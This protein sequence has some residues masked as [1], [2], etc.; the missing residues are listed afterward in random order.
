MIFYH[1]ANIVYS[2][3]SKSSSNTVR[4]QPPAP[5]KPPRGFEL[6][7]KD[8][9]DTTISNLFSK[10]NLSG[11][12][13]W[14]ITAPASVPASAITKISIEHSKGGISHNGKDYAFI[15][16][17]GDEKKAT[18]LLIPSGSSQDYSFGMFD[19][20]EGRARLMSV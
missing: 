17:N 15:Q 19:W 10:S 2:G 4:F 8:S 18:K 5:F 11:K 20:Y 1:I 9:D 7:S 16:D 3:A 12:E 14:Y 6:A 13:I